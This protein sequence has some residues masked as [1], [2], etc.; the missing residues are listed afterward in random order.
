MTIF[1]LLV[2]VLAI[3]IIGFLVV[4]TRTSKAREDETECVDTQMGPITT[5]RQDTLT[6]GATTLTKGGPFDPTATQVYGRAATDAIQATPRKREGTSA[7]VVT[8][9]RLV[10]LSGSCKGRIF[11]IGAKGLTVGRNSS[12]DVVLSDPRISSR[13]AWI[14]LVGGKAILRD[15]KSTN[16][17][18][19][20]AQI[21][22]SVTE[23]E[24]RQNDT[25]FFGGHQGD[26]FRFVLE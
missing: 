10:A 16:G 25:V 4:R 24:L 12:C 2:A 21:H 19:L 8:G 20:N 5:P 7:P 15:T 23:V 3:V 22:T 9:A 1:Y 6:R 11:P 14:G 26:Q 13:H 17:T 18:F